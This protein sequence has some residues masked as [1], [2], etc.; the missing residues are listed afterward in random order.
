MFFSPAT[1][2]QEDRDVEIREQ[3][4]ELQVHEMR[5]ELSVGNVATKTPETGVRRRAQTRVSNMRQEVHVQIHINSPFEIL[6]EKESALRGD[7]AESRVVA[8]KTAPSSKIHELRS[9]SR[10][11]TNLRKLFCDIIQLF[12]L[13]RCHLFY[14]DN[15]FFRK[16]VYNSFAKYL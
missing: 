2:H 4:G 3:A 15:L 13:E 1:D 11:C 12:P 8:L 9:L 14:G 16:S 6:Q 5:Q 7:I 10:L